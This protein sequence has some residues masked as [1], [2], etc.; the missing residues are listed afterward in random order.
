MENEVE[1]QNNAPKEGGKKGKSITALI[2]GIVSF[3]FSCIGL[4]A[5]PSGIIGLILGILGRKSESAKGMAT[6]GIV[7]S[8]LGILGAILWIVLAMIGISASAS[9]FMYY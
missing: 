1:V 6:T 9:E 5:F 8:I 4:I 3:V 2:L 7:F